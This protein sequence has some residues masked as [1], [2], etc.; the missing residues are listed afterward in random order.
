M[1]GRNGHVARRD[2]T[3]PLL[4]DV[5]IR[6]LKGK[7]EW[8]RFI[9]AWVAPLLRDLYATLTEI[10]PELPPM[11]GDLSWEAYRNESA[12]SLEYG[13]WANGR[14]GQL[15]DETQRQLLAAAPV[16]AALPS[17]HL[18]GSGLELLQALATKFLPR[19]GRGR[20]QSTKTAE[21]NRRLTDLANDHGISSPAKLRD[22]ALLDAVIQKL[23]VKVTAE[24][25]RNVLTPGRGRKPRRKNRA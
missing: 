4:V 12:E 9:E 22:L 15:F 23:D 8:P 19:R 6:P 21:R 16:P 24:I 5:P 14:L 25:C 10:I 17:E 11:A 18:A 3:F 13:E 7:D 2:T 1:P 20:P